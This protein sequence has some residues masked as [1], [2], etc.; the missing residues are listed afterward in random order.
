M[1]MAGAEQCLRLASAKP[2]AADAPSAMHTVH[3]DRK[4]QTIPSKAL[5]GSKRRTE[6]SSRHSSN[7]EQGLPPAR[8]FVI[9]HA[10]A[11]SR[12]QRRWAELPD[13]NMLYSAITRAEKTGRT[14]GAFEDD[15]DL[16]CLAGVRRSAQKLGNEIGR[17]GRAGG[18]SQVHRRVQRINGR[19]A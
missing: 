2:F 17:R 9:G 15:G 14:I 16:E 8:N 18:S 4:K 3:D 13:D 12:T 5:V 11:R 19:R 1:V 10:A 7:I 6:R